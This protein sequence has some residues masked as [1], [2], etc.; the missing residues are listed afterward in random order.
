[1]LS[2][3]ELQ[4]VL[5]D[6][7][8]TLNNRLLSYVEDDIQ[9][10][11]LT[12]NSMLLANSNVLPEE[13][14]DGVEDEDLRKRAR[15]LKKCKEAVWRRWST[16]YLRSLRERHHHKLGKTDPPKVGDVV[17]VK[18]D[19]KK[20]GKWPIGIVE[21]LIVGK[22]K[23]VRGAR[24]RSGKS[25]IERAIQHLY[26]LELSYVREPRPDETG[27]NPEARPFRPRRDAAVAA[28][29]RIQEIENQL[30]D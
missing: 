16:E 25:Y 13:D 14:P 9:F 3:K 7:E 21:E 27:L 19:D 2:W 8:V 15:H 17:L 29:H 18:S 11:V 20:R 30:R 24:L 4:E 6:V 28:Q 10:P 1:M 23:V 12:P 26:P 5:L 22:D